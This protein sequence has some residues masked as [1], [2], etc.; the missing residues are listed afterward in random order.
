MTR[1]PAPAL[2][3]RD[4]APTARAG[5]GVRLYCRVIDNFG[6]AGIAW[7]LAR[8]LAD[9]H[10]SDVTLV[11]D[12]PQA[13]A[14]LLGEHAGRRM[15]A[16]LAVC[17]TASVAGVAIQPWP[18]RREGLPAGTDLVIAAFGCEL[19][20]SVRA[21]LAP[22]DPP[23]A[24][25]VNLEYL[26][27]EAWID[28]THGLPSI[29]P[30]DGAIE[31]FVM[32]GFGP[33]TG[34]LLRERGLFA[35]RDAFERDAC[36]RP[37][38]ASLGVPDAGSALRVSLFCYP[39]APVAA[40]LDEAARS[41]TPSQWLV[42]EGIA[43]SALRAWAGH[44]PAPGEALSRGVVQLVGLPW[45]AQ[46]DYDRLLWSC[47][48]N[49]VRGEDSWVRAVWAARPFVWQA[50]RQEGG[51]HRVKLDAFLDRLLDGAP[52]A[53]SVAMRSMHHRWLD[54]VPGTLPRG[55]THDATALATEPATSPAPDACLAPALDPSAGWEALSACVR[56]PALRL[57]L[58]EFAERTA[59]VAD[60][61]STLLAL[62]SR[63]GAGRA[64]QSTAEPPMG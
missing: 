36:A 43:E 52:A 26:S 7:R 23:P 59:R 9:E 5:I 4:V 33:R 29:K 55:V 22:A 11:I 39:H 25:W 15:Q 1:S 48:L 54:D 32:P 63:V 16:A 38:L 8:Q 57:H 19:P 50:Y 3:D 2:P 64:R 10:G 60:L 12:A 13:L 56:S 30:R 44:A 18:G 31:W 17:G 37:W 61:A 28:E 34:G 35:A 21:A 14:R 40:L 27:A 6:D 62:A 20:A 46:P 53:A 49:F 47:D 42:P 41:T 58:H 24:C 51:T 45:L